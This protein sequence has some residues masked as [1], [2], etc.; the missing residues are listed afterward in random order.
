MEKEFMAI[1][2][3]ELSQMIEELHLQKEYIPKYRQSKKEKRYMTMH[4]RNPNGKSTIIRRLRERHSND[5]PKY[6][7]LL[8]LIPNHSKI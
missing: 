5:K 1:K 7:I 2:F 6:P 8:T 4:R 3:S